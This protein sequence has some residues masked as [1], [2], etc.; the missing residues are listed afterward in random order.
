MCGQV[1]LSFGRE[2]KKHGHRVEAQHSSCVT[3]SQLK[4]SQTRTRHFQGQIALHVKQRVTDSV[5]EYWA[6][7]LALSYT[8]DVDR[9]TALN[10]KP[11]H[12]QY[13]S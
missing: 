12:K 1:C 9:Q 4:H 10:S 2:R 7:L 13:L 3:R 8:A 5:L 11:N 6:P